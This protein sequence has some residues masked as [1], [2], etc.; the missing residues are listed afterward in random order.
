MKPPTATADEFAFTPNSASAP[1]MP[2]KPKAAPEPEPESEPETIGGFDFGGDDPVTDP[3]PFKS[4]KRRPEP[5]PEEEDD[6]APKRS[7][8]KKSK[9]RS[10]SKEPADANRLLWLS[11]AGGGGLAA[12]LLISGVIAWSLSGSTP[13]KVAAAPKAALPKKGDKNTAKFPDHKVEPVVEPIKP[14]IVPPGPD[15]REANGPLPAGLGAEAMQR[16]KKAT[17][18]IKVTSDSDRKA[19]GS[20]WFGLNGTVVT[21]AHVVGM[22]EPYTKEPKKLEIVINSGMPDEKV[23][24]G[25]VLGVDRENDLALVSVSGQAKDWPEPLSFSKSDSLTELQDVIVFGFPLGASLGRGSSGPEITVAKTTISAFRRNEVGNLRLLQVAGGLEHGNSG[26]PIVDTRGAVIGVSV[27]G[28]D[29]TMIKFAV[30]GD[31]VRELVDGRV[32]DTRIYEPF[33]EGN[34][35]RLP[36]EIETLDPLRR[37]KEVNVEIWAGAPG[38][39]RP[40]SA[41]PPAKKDGDGPRSVVEA[42][43]ETEKA[44]ADVDMPPIGKDKVIWVQPIVTDDQGRKLWG[45]AEPMTPNGLPPLERTPTAFSVQ[46]DRPA[47][48]TVVKVRDDERTA[49]SSGA[50]ANGTST[51]QR[52]RVQDPR[53]NRPQGQRRRRRLVPRRGASRR[54][55]LRGEDHQVGAAASQRRQA[56]AAPVHARSLRP[57][58]ESDDPASRFEPRE[59]GAR[60]LRLHRKRALQHLPDDLDEP[61][62]PE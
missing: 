15:L 11:I 21:N 41:T 2:S 6:E 47:E 48:R 49:A 16:V 40:G 18:Y 42:R 12:F 27:S 43:L 26:G 50:S 8:K 60:R 20:G 29:G 4:K 19:S 59:E 10:R 33:K 35:V 39:P 58:R 51:E 25:Q 17:A 61:A 56:V 24:T 45:V 54:E 44:M 38:R 28:F 55:G 36:V 52:Q 7:D 31:K 1:P 14:L 46:L 23:F 62:G 9:N 53:E 5:E 57:D 3:A 22:K 37:I 30:P 32:A 13:A 34:A